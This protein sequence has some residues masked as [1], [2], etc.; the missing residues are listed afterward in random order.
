MNRP[1]IVLFLRKKIPG[2]NSIEELAYSIAKTIPEMEIKVFPEYG[3]SI[4]GILKNIYFAI[5][6]Q[7]DINHLFSQS[8]PYIAPFLKGKKIITWHDVGT[9]LQSKSWI[10]RFLRKILY[11]YP[12]R[13]YDSVTCISEY[14]KE[15]LLSYVPSCRKKTKVIPNP[16][17]GSIRFSKKNFDLSE[18]NILHI[19]TAIRKNLENTIKALDGIRCKL[20]I[21]GKLT[22]SQKNLLDKHHIKYSNESDVEF[23]TVIKR[24]QECDIISFPSLYEGFGM[25]VIEGNMTGRPVLTT[26]RGAIP[27]IAQDCVFY[28]DP[29]NVE[30]I[31]TGFLQLINDGGLRDTLINK[32]L[33]NA[34]RIHITRISSAYQDLYYS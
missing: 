3:T 26:R 20:H 7:G 12:T 16:L 28:V 34:R 4:K 8:D 19:G 27:E 17:N 24:Y 30:S 18:P 22:E 1:K 11:F 13:F 32:G 21:I 25:P 15:E 2:E 29:E 5:E 33:Q 31:R 23:E 10:K 14:T 6:N 9:L